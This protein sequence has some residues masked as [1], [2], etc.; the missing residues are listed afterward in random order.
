MRS[1]SMRDN[2][3][4]VGLD[5]HADTIAVAVA[6]PGGEVASLGIISNKSTSLRKLIKRLG[7]KKDLRF[8][9]EA[10]PCGYVVFRQL[11]QMGV[12][13][14]VIAPS[15]VP[16]TP[17]DRVKTDRRDARKL[18]TCLRSGV[19]TPVW[20]PDED[21]EAI[22]DLVRARQAAKKDRSRARQRLMKYLL[23][24]DKRTPSGTRTWSTKYWQWLDAIRFHNY[25]LDVVLADYRHEVR[26]A[27]ER[28]ESLERSIDEALETC[29]ETTRALV[30][31]LQAFRGIAK[32]TAVGLVS[33]IGRFSRFDHPTQ[34]MSYVGNVPS[35]HSSAGRTRR[36]P[37]TKTGN[38]Y[39]RLL[40]TEAAWSY[41]YAPNLYPTLRRRQQGVSMEVKEVAWRAQRRLHDR[42]RHLTSRGKKPQKTITAVGR[43]LLAFIWEA[44]VEIEKQMVA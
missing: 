37:I 28:I 38:A 27:D 11:E 10:G 22:R 9:Y 34:L 30:A 1:R 20:V 15:L 36:G 19:L 33:E 35:E 42:Y 26:H 29:D 14:E 40:V 24:H 17:G 25:A 5:V 2:T 4:F 32:V 12:R 23:R 7:S 44:G 8:C 6:E 18:A 39:C 43:E 21:H 41:R 16:V 3:R 13:C 31:G